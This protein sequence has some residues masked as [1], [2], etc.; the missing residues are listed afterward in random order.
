MARANN[1]QSFQ[2]NKASVKVAPYSEWGRPFQ[3][4]L[5]YGLTPNASGCIQTVIYY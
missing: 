3:K 4:P 1:P 2:V 5:K